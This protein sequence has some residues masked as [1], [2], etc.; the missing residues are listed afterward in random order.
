MY[1]QDSKENIFIDI[2]TSGVNCV[3]CFCQR[4]GSSV[5]GEDSA[6]S[7]VMSG[8]TSAVPPFQKVL[9]NFLDNYAPVVGEYYINRKAQYK[10]YNLLRNLQ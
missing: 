6:S 3:L 10:K 8:L 1:G 4:E 5:Q 9:M 2:G 7:N